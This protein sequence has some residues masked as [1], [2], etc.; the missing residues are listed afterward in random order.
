MVRACVYPLLTC[1]AGSFSHRCEAC[2]DWRARRGSLCEGSCP[3][4]RTL[5]SLLGDKVEDKCIPASGNG[6][7]A[8]SGGAACVL[9][10]EHLS[11]AVKC[12]KLRVQASEGRLSKN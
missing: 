2:G 1:N 7:P 8:A 6:R 5:P 10:G 11:Q 12:A 3:H 4:D 9:Q